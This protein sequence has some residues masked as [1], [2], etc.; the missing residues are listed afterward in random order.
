MANVEKYHSLRFD[1]MKD[2]HEGLRLIAHFPFIVHLIE[3][4]RD[5]LKNEER[6]VSPLT[7]LVALEHLSFLVDV[8]KHAKKL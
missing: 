4:V 3:N 6:Y 2:H 1:K 7:H 5:F 8:Y